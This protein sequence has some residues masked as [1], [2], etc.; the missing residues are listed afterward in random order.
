MSAS[1]SEPPATGG[2]ADYARL[3]FEGRD[4]QPTFEALLARATATPADVGAMLDLSTLLQLAGQREQGLALQADAL[5]RQRHYRKKLGTGDGPRLLALVAAG[6]LMAS[7]PVEF[8]L[9]GWNGEL[10]LVFLTP[11]DRLDGVTEHDIALL[12][13]GESDA[14]AP[15]LAQLAETVRRWPRPLL[16]GD[17]DAI[18]ALGRDRAPARLAG[19]PSLVAPPTQRIARAELAT[20]NADFPVIVRPVDSHAGAGLE[21]LDSP[22]D[23]AGYLARQAGEQFYLQ[24]FVDYAGPDGRFRKLRIALVAGR[25]FIVHMAVSEHWMVHY[26][27]A[28]MAEDAGKRAEEAAMMAAF[29]TGFAARHAA[30][31]RA[32]HAAFGLD[33]F[34]ID[35]A[36]DREGRLLLFEADTAMIVHD[37]DPPDLHPYKRPAMARLL[38]AFQALITA[39]LGG[40]SSNSIAP[41]RSID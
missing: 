4:V 16:N 39:R 30:A 9:A 31:F 29:D 24:P 37:M 26:L 25:P 14:N 34:A 40:S 12:A 23:L 21:K 32:L 38:A 20:L 8:L 33:Y 19:A 2:L 11:G 1:G 41:M 7:T 17:P 13:I 5:A 28:G 3:I 22:A 15:I 27:N 18:R 6:D 35:C 10:D 36:E